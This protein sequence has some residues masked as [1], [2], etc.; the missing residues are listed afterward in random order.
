MNWDFSGQVAVVTG[1]ASG[2]GRATALLL[3]R[4][5]ARVFGCDLHAEPELACSLQAQGVSLSACDVTSLPDLKQ[6]IDE[7]AATGGGLTLLINNAGINLVGPPEVIE[8]AAW[9]RCL[10]V[11]LKAAFFGVKYALPYFQ[12]AGKGVV[13]NTASNAGLLPRHHDPVYSLSKVALVGLTKALALNLA[14]DQVRVNC[15]CPGPVER[16]SLL[17][18]DLEHAADREQLVTSIINASPLARAAGRMMTPEEVAQSIAFLCS[19]AAAMITGTA[20]A[21]D[22]GKSLGVPPPVAP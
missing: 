17:D 22:G 4:Q 9:D 12:A 16:T 18:F 21:I 3:A 8:E 13:I 1:A 15:V 5:G 6:F 19:D 11:N 7:S 20:L 14:R 10:D 2:I